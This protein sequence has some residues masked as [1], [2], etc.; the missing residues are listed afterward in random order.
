MRSQGGSQ[1]DGNDAL[2]RRGVSELPIGLPGEET[3]ETLSVGQEGSHQTL[4]VLHCRPQPQ[5][6]KCLLLKPLSVAFAVAARMD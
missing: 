3:G 6:N 2:I 1:R 4:A 5:E